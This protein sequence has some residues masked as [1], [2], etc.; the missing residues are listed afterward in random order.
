MKSLYTPEAEQEIL[1]RIE[2]L[3]PENQ[4]QWGKMQADQM[5]A[6]CTAALETATG[7]KTPPRLF[8]GK[9]LGPLVKKRTLGDNPFPKNSPTDKSFVIAE[10]RDFN[11]EKEKLVQIIKRYA[12]G[13]E[14]NCTKQPHSFF[15]KMTPAEWGTLMYKHL[16][17]HLKQFSA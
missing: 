3:T 15:G 4:R 7:D 6:H 16:D 14:A 8:I 12:A 2:K 9:I 13:G 5:L 17:H 1:A 10:R 11:A